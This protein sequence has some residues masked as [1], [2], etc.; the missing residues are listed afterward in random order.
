MKIIEFLCRTAILVNA[1]LIAFTF[2]YLPNLLYRELISTN[3]TLD[4]YVDFMMA[5]HTVNISGV[6]TPCR[7][8]PVFKNQF[9]SELC[10]Q[11]LIV[12]YFA[13][14]CK[15]ILYILCANL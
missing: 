8:E 1:V 12:I 15:I 11:H 6:E 13:L 5:H 2:D 4:G 10:S 9:F 7:S 14:S 3:G